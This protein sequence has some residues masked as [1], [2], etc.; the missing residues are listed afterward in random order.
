M[1]DEIGIV[2]TGLVGSTAAYA[3]VMRG[4]G[5]EIVLVDRNAARA[6]AEADDLFHAVPFAS[7]LNVH[8]GD[9]PDLKGARVVVITAGANQKPGE[10]RLQLLG[11]N[12]AIFRDIVPR[13]LEHAPEAVL[14]VATNPVDIMTHLTAQIAAEH[15]L[16]EGRVLGSGTTLDT[17]R[18]R[19]LLGHELGVELGACACLCRGRARRLRGAHLVAGHDSAASRSKNS[20][21]RSARRS[22]KT[23]TRASTS[24]CAAPRTT[25]SRA[26][27][28]RTTASAARWPASSTSS[29]ATS[30][31]S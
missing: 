6:S 1:T 18:F 28:R 3:M 19:V 21:A 20:A 26:K 14:V 22:A 17:A 30:A 12:A 15:G 31:P 9:Y 4:V 16:P 24:T 7:Q 29:C 2:G 5:R 27:A 25:S 8:D 11:R 13:V 23:T 10:T